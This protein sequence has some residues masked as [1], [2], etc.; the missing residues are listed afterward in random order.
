MSE[1]EI[2]KRLITGIFAKNNE[3]CEVDDSIF[4]QLVRAGIEEAAKDDKNIYTELFDHAI[5][6]YIDE[7]LEYALKDEKRPDLDIE[8]SD[9]KKA[10]LKYFSKKL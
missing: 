10:F 5:K 4:I 3:L 8:A 7:W 9:S 2:T 6:L 1:L